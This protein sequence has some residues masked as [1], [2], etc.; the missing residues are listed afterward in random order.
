MAKFQVIGL[1]QVSKTEVRFAGPV[2]ILRMF[3]E[4]IPEGKAG[5]VTETGL[6]DF[7][8]SLYIYGHSLEFEK[9]VQLHLEKLIAEGVPAPAP[10]P[11][12]R[13]APRSRR[14]VYAA[15]GLAAAAAAIWVVYPATP[16]SPAPLAGP[17]VYSAERK[18]PQPKKR[19]ADERPKSVTVTFDDPAAP[20]LPALGTL[21]V[22][23]VDV[24]QGDA[25]LIDFPSGKK[26]LIDGGEPKGREHLM[27]YLESQ[28]IQKVDAVVLTHPHL[29]HLAALADVIRQYEVGK[30][31]EPVYEQTTRAYRKFLEAVEEKG[32]AY[33]QAKKGMRIDM[34]KET[35]VRILS[36]PDPFLENTRSD[37][38]NSSVVLHVQHGEVSFLFTG[39]IE[40]EIED[41]LVV[42]GGI[43]ANVLK[44]PHHGGAH[45]SQDRFL[46]AVSPEI[47]LISCGKGNSYGHPAPSSL[48]RYNKIGAKIYRTDK[49]G[50]IKAIS[51]GRTLRVETENRGGPA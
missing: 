26:M 48:I 33:E 17:G 50:T 23:M 18:T 39:D 27:E 7:P 8:Y 28:R 2:E 40:A 21:T 22:H 10:A 1:P 35:A 43:R 20:A 3:R 29:D 51:N 36:P 34:G 5:D 38:N 45:S 19:K 14:P 30:V 25:L 12:P 9:N 31:Y 6:P 32:V 37:V 49:S 4:K 46:E 15:A 47:V 13:R 44:A 42:D 24:K 41:R 11:E 16:K